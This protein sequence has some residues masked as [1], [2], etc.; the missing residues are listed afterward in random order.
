[1]AT[2]CRGDRF[3]PI[4]SVR[5]EHF[6]CADFAG[7]TIFTGTTIAVAGDHRERAGEISAR[8]PSGPHGVVLG[9][10]G[11]T[12]IDPNTTSSANSSGCAGNNSTAGY[13]R[14]YTSV[15]AGRR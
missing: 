5:Y 12:S 4:I 11:A 13:R 3:R 15:C 14:R 8:R 2:P 1:M 7:T 6:H 9:P 10:A